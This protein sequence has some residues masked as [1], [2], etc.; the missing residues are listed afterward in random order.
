MR[1]F[2]PPK[3]NMTMEKNTHL[4]MYLI[5]KNG[6]FPASHVSFWGDVSSL[7]NL[8]RDSFCY[9]AHDDVFFLC[10]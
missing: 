2:P 9:V 3:T 4:K 6:D 5:F 1:C 7:M 8:L 10:W